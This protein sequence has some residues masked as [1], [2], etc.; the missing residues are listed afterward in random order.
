MKVIFAYVARESVAAIVDAIRALHRRPVSVV[1]V[2]AALWPVA[3]D[4]RLH[5]PQLGG[6]SVPDAKLEVLCD[7]DD[8]AALVDVIHR[9]VHGRLTSAN[10]VYVMSVDSRGVSALGTP[11]P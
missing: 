11:T 10:G 5:L 9:V 1:E 8:V 3:G 6:P 2:R 7:E 4:S